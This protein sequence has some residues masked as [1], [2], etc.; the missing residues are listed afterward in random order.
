MFVESALPRMVRTSAVDHHPKLPGDVLM[1]SNLPTV[2]MGHRETKRRGQT[3]EYL[4]RRSEEFVCCL[5]FQDDSTAVPGE[6]LGER[7]DGRTADD[8]I[9]LPIPATLPTIDDLRAFADVSAVGNVCPQSLRET[10][11][12][13]SSSSAAQV[14]MQAATFRRHLPDVTVDALRRNDMRSMPERCP[15]HAPLDLLGTLTLPQEF[16]NESEHLRIV[17]PAPSVLVGS[18]TSFLRTFLC[19]V[20]LVAETIG[21]T[22]ASQLPADRGLGTTDESCHLGLTL[23]ETTEDFQLI[24]LGAAKMNHTVGGKGC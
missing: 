20:S 5:V 3:H 4:P 9:A 22:T 21:W 18:R 15:F 12:L 1:P 23:S 11:P 14:Q 7:G 16:K 6:S 19:L 17:V 13:R 24:P 8:E 2:V 10:K